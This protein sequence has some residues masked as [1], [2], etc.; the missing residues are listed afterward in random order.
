MA[1]R[2]NAPPNW[3]APPVG[4]TPPADWKPDPAWGP[5]P[6]GWQLWVDDSEP[7]EIAKPKGSW[8]NRHKVLTG[9]GAAAAVLVVAA[10]ASGGGD[11][12]A[13]AAADDTVAV[14]PADEKAP[15]AE[16][17]TE[18]PSEAPAE[19][20]APEPAPAAAGLNTPVRDGK[21][22]FV[23]TGVECGQTTLGDEYI[24]TTAQGQ[25]CLVHVRATNIG[26]KPQYF[27]ADNQK[28]FNADGQEYSANSS[29]SIYLDDADSWMSEINPGNGI[30][31][32]VVFDVPV[33]VTPTSVELHDS[34]FSGGVKVVLG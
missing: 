5:V 27:F 2:F 20:A 34:A 33:G 1:L 9:V 22:E 3:P 12:G 15:P 18:T 29:A 8:I 21:F 17:P 19:P 10:I 7:A 32:T 25:F 23:V 6:D 24:N 11:D 16:A 4:W 28:A 31:G 30:D 13:P 14:A 26:D